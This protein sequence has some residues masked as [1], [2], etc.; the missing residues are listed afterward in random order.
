MKTGLLKKMLGAFVI[1]LMGANVLAQTPV[2]QPQGECRVREVLMIAKSTRG[3]HLSEKDEG[4]V[5]GSY[6][7]LDCG[8]HV[9]IDEPSRVNVP[10]GQARPVV[11][12]PNVQDCIAP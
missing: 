6:K 4:R 11:C 12:P 9:V 1:V 10:V 2:T 7:V 8:T 5:I 3:V